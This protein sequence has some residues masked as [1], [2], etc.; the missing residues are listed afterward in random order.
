MIESLFGDGLFPNRNINYGNFQLTT[1][2]NIP[3]EIDESKPI[4][5]YVSYIRGGG[6]D[7]AINGISIS[8]LDSLVESIGKPMYARDFNLVDSDY[9][10]SSDGS[11]D[12]YVWNLEG[13]GFLYIW[14]SGQFQ[15]NLPN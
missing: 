2:K 11:P 12:C 1:R 7:L 13:K 5:S 10:D 4:M 15:I 8:D 9:F 14:K 3:K 6:E